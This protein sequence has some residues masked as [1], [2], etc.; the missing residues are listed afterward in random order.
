MPLIVRLLP[1]LLRAFKIRSGHLL[2][3]AAT[4]PHTGRHTVT[5]AAEVTENGLT[6]C[7][8]SG[9]LDHLFPTGILGVR[10][11]LP[12]VL[13]IHSRW[14][15]MRGCSLA[16]PP[17]HVEPSR[18]ESALA[19]HVPC[20]AWAGRLSASVDDLVSKQNNTTA[21]LFLLFI[22]CRVKEVFFL[23]HI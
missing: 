8:G 5:T 20:C 18:W 3:W 9:I 16:K 12:P 6:G 4:L 22:F 13:R 7:V 21:E 14:T 2:R 11:S 10:A 23:L 19:S 17:S 15:G 1:C